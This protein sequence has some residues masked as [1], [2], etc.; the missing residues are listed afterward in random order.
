MNGFWLEFWRYFSL[1]ACHSLIAYIMTDCRF[2]R[3]A[4]RLIW[5]LLC[6]FSTVFTVGITLSGSLERSWLYIG[7]SASTMFAYMACYVYVSYGAWQKKLFLFS[8]YAT[9]YYLV[10]QTAYVFNMI[11]FP[12]SLWASYALRTLFFCFIIVLMFRYWRQIMDALEA[13]IDGNWGILAFFGLATNGV[14]YAAT[15]AWVFLLR[16]EPLP[17]LAVLLTELGLVVVE[18]AAL[19]RIVI[20]LGQQQTARAEEAQRKLLENQ[21][22]AERTYVEQARAHRHD[23]QHYMVAI[24]GYIEQRDWDGAKAYLAEHQALLDNERLTVF[25]ENIVANALLRLYQNRC[26]AEGVACEIRVAIP[27]QIALSGLEM[28][29]VLGNVLENAWEANS[30]A[31]TPKLAVR[32]YNL[33]KMLLIEVENGVAGEVKFREG[34]PQTNKA[35]GGLGLRNVVKVLDKH[36]GML[37]CTQQGDTF[38]TQIILPI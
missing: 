11:L 9:V 22:A 2:S 18:Y 30:R 14:V 29:T 38:C 34:L 19:V 32:A 7:L 26:Q 33:N 25:C 5:T 21:V 4:N 15:L 16:Y 1:F 20:L 31:L 8:I 12:N 23:M 37:Q 35:G 36:G 6:V 24:G 13:N 3:R 10:Q 17:W 28:A 27:E